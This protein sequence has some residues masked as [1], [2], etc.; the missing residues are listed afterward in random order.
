MASTSAET[1]TGQAGVACVLECTVRWPTDP[2]VPTERTTLAARVLQGRDD[3]AAWAEAV[4]VLR[5]A[6]GVEHESPATVGR[7]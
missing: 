4:S 3:E 7:G 5:T 2:E 1:V 6:E